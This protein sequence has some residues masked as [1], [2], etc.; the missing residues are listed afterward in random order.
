MGVFLIV[1]EAMKVYVIHGPPLSG[2]STYVQNHKGRNDIIFDYDLIMSAISGLEVHEHNKSLVGYVLD[3]RDLIIAKLKSETNID[4]AW[5][6]TTR[7]TLGLKKQLIGLNAEYIEIKIDINTARKRLKDNPENR[8]TELWNE[9]ID[10]YYATTKDYSAFYKSKDWLH[11]RKVVLKRDGYECRECKRYGKVVEANTV[12]HVIPLAEMYDLKLD[13][14]NL[15][16]LCDEHH[17]NMHN[18]F[19]NELSKLGVEWRD[20]I[21]M[22]YPELINRT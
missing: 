2:K 5:I 7:V 12:H 13:R 9:L 19:T 21:I 17:E 15:I 4:T 10:R 6:I 20:R 1:G 16:S 18:R 8:D 14:R 22:K 3:I 11:V